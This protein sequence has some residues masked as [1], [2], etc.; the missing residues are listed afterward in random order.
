[1]DLLL[2]ELPQDTRDIIGSYIGIKVNKSIYYLNK[3]H[4][5]N[6]YNIIFEIINYK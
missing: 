5:E 6:S 1:M 2:I 4:Y 3:K